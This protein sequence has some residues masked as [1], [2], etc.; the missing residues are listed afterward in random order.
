MSQVIT[1]ALI[2]ILGA[3]VGSLGQEFAQGMTPTNA[4]NLGFGCGCSCLVL[5]LLFR[6]RK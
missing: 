3:V 2:M 1:L 5:S 6:P 4:F